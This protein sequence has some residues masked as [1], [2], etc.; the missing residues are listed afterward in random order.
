MVEIYLD[1]NDPLLL[2]SIPSSDIQRLSY[3]PLKW[4][5]FVTFT[6]CGARGDLLRSHNGPIVD[7]ETTSINDVIGPYYYHPT[8]KGS[9]YCS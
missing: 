2:L 6:I 1:F 8:G 7:Y 3:R 9:F 4:L 5:R